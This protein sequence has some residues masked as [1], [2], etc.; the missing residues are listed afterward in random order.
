[1]RFGSLAINVALVKLPYEP[2]ICYRI[3]P[4][5]CATSARSYRSDARGAAQ[6]AANRIVVVAHCF[7]AR[8]THAGK[9]AN[10]EE[11]VS[12]ESLSHSTK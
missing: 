2:L 5:V 11:R 12:S 7:H 8:L 6:L 3:P 1:L 10:G 9:L 4:S